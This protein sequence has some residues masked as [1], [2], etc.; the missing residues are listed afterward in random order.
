MLVSL[1]YKH[2]NYFDY[3]TNQ[4]NNIHQ[5]LNNKLK[6][7]IIER[8]LKSEN[9]N[10]INSATLILDIMGYEISKD[11]YNERDSFFELILINMEKWTNDTLE[12]LLT[13]H[14]RGM[15][16]IFFSCISTNKNEN[17]INSVLIH[18]VNSFYIISNNL[19][20]NSIKFSCF[21]KYEQGGKE[22]LAELI[23]KPENT[24]KLLNQSEE[25]QPK[26]SIL[27]S[28]SYKNLNEILQASLNFKNI[29]SAAIHYLSSLSE[30][31]RLSMALYIKFFKFLQDD[32]SNSHLSDIEKSK[33]IILILVS[34]STRNQSNNNNY[35]LEDF[36]TLLEEIQKI[37]KQ[38]GEELLI[39]FCE[40]TQLLKIPSLDSI[41]RIL[42]IINVLLSN[43]KLID[44]LYSHIQ[45]FSSNLCTLS[46][47]SKNLTAM[48]I[49]N[50]SYEAVD[51]ISIEDL[52]KKFAGEDPSVLFPLDKKSIEEIGKQYRSIQKY[53]E[54]W[55]SINTD[56]LIV[57]ANEIKLNSIELSLN[58][59]DVLKL[60]AIGRL[61]IRN[62]FGIY[63]Y[64]TQIA[65]L[66]GLLLYEKEGCFIQVKTGE[67]KSWSVALLAFI[68][69]IQGRRV[70][71]ISSSLSLA[72]RD[73]RECESFFNLFGITTSSIC[74]NHYKNAEF[75]Q[76]LIV[77][78]VASDYQFAIMHEMLHGIKLFPELLSSNSSGKRFEFAIIDEV[79][80]L[81]IDTALNSA[82]ISHNAEIN[83][84][85]V[86]KPIL[87]FI[88]GK[89]KKEDYLIITSEQTVKSLKKYLANYMKG[90]FS[91]L[92]D[93]LLDD[94]IKNWLICGYKALFILKNKIDYIIEESNECTS[95]KEIVIIDVEN[96]GKKMYGM[97][98][99]NGLHEF[100]EV[101]HDILVQQESVTPI[102]LSKAAFYDMYTSLFG[103]TGTLGSKIERK[104]LKEI[105]GTHSF[106]IPTHNLLKRID[107]QPTIVNSDSSYLNFI[108]NKVKECK[109]KKQPLLILCKTIQDTENIENLMQ[110]QSISYLMLNEMQKENE[111]EVIEKCGLPGAVTIATNTAARGTDIKLT[112]ESIENGGLFV[113]IT[114]D[115]GS[116]R[117][118]E[119]ARGRAGRQ[120]QPGETEIVIHSKELGFLK[121]DQIDDNKTQIMLRKFI[122]DKRKKKA[123]LLKGIHVSHANLEKYSFSLVKIF[124]GKLNKF[125]EIISNE[126]FLKTKSEVLGSRKIIN[127]NLIISQEL[128]SQD[129]KIAEDVIQLLTQ[130]E[131][132]PIHWQIL[133]KSIHKRVCDRVLNDF[134]INFHKRVEEII[135]DPELSILT[136]KLDELKIFDNTNLLQLD[137]P[138]N[139]ILSKSLKKEVDQLI[140]GKFQKIK[141]EMEKIFKER[142][143][144]WESSLD[145]NGNG[146]IDYIRDITKI[147]LIHLDNITSSAIDYL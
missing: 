18:I 50:T 32:F 15:G 16:E 55:K 22:L 12:K 1:E 88:Q 118:E 41:I 58:V 9:L 23:N 93:Q 73:Q 46:V 68:L 113:L 20:D 59:K 85:W 116:D 136:E 90:K 57:I 66:L 33:V 130:Q 79:D 38:G 87:T 145:S 26:N 13:I 62:E 76:S 54:K 146:L 64:N 71:I 144:I 83:N 8:L 122:K 49:E 78:G 103:L 7:F 119:Q 80:N 81:T 43:F 31:C 98:W 102:S 39:S 121:I 3:L 124:Y 10:D 5:S 114:F 70:H 56:D 142:S 75:Y 127:Y 135:N 143:V 86:Y 107:R 51:K 99:G 61:V 19:I 104:E 28:P 30:K 74:E 110:Q 125:R 100:V 27:H 84:N 91:D 60:F 48:I 11:L 17:Y 138:I 89:I 129:Q 147:N 132:N 53:C 97:R 24:L 131:K 112:N 94:Q 95:E 72:T 47:L 36:N 92:S 111:Q 45:D 137:N 123:S 14:Q 21:P 101:K 42:R 105:Y 35:F 126:R 44:L 29:K 139:R 141:M 4:Q 128:H 96:T 109:S 108:R 25:I 106:D 52:L 82:R 69:A 2:F 65:S 63:L 134:A 115:T 37:N 77:Y 67:G 34:T 133:L 140:Q 40:S 6:D 120:G 117:V